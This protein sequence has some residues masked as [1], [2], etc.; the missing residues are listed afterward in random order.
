MKKADL[1]FHDMHDE[2]LQRCL[3]NDSIKAW[4]MKILQN[5]ADTNDFVEKFLS[6]EEPAIL[7]HYAYAELS[8][9][10]RPNEH[11]M[12][13][14]KMIGDKQFKTIA[15]MGG[16]KI[17]N[18]NFSIIIPSGG[19]DGCVRVAIVNRGGINKNMLDFFTSVRG[20][21][22]IFSCDCGDDIKCTITGEYGIYQREG[23][24]VFEKW[25]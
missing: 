9:R 10:V 7:N 15:D 16:V 22:N 18:D 3:F 20:K 2:I 4:T 1:K 6:S 8:K 5:A 19:G 14:R 13:I 11:W 21:I 23:F 12:R 17:G 24:V 25:N